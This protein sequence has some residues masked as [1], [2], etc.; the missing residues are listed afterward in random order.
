MIYLD[1]ENQSMDEQTI[2]IDKIY[3]DESLCFD[4]YKVIDK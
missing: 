3:Y 1:R 2:D 4:H